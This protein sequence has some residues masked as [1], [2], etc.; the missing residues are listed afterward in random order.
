MRRSAFDAG[1]AQFYLAMATGERLT[2]LVP[3]RSMQFDLNAERFVDLRFIG[4]V[5]R[6]VFMRHGTPDL[7]VIVQ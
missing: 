1:P 4:A 7:N 5:M 3:F 6:H 2:N